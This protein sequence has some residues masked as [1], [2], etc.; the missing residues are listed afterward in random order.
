MNINYAIVRHGYGCHNA[1]RP[2]YKHK[3]ITSKEASDFLDIKADPELAPL[4]VDA[5]VHN[6]CIISR[7]IKNLHKVTGNPKI[8]MDYVNIVGCSGLIRSM[9]TAYFMTRKWKYPPEKIYVFPYLREIDESSTNKYSLSSRRT[10]DREPSYAMKSIQEQKQYLE[11]VGILDYFDFSFVEDNLIGRKEPGDIVQFTK[12][13]TSTF[14]PLIDKDDIG[15]SLNVFV[16]THAGVLRDYSDQGF[17]NNSGFVI[18]TTYNGENTYKEF[19]SLDDFLP[20]TFFSSYNSAQYADKDYFCP[21][22]RCG[23]LC[24]N[25]P[26]QGKLKQYKS[27]C[28]NTNEES[29]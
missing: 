16:V 18:N 11:S 2:L 19:V 1:V 7:I 20:S 12:W 21:S 25:D 23:T 5:S 27:E 4:G 24:K 17:R 15:R 8:K 10:I 26:R 29:I 9:E 13:F 22:G 14:V 6:G 28:N 3:S